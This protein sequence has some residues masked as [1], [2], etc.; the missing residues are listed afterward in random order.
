[1]ED[2]PKHFEGQNAI[3]MIF[4]D[5]VELELKLQKLERVD[6]FLP[7]ARTVC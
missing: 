7:H 1:M 3:T 2:L 4:F 6:I 5:I